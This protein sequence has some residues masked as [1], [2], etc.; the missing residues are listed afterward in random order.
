MKMLRSPGQRR[1]F[2]V[3][4]PGDRTCI[5]LFCD[6]S[7]A[8][9][10]PTL[11]ALIARIEEGSLRMPVTGGVCWVDVLEPG[12]ELEAGERRDPDP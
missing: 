7:A 6:A 2:I 9:L 5:D 3:F 8:D 11:K 12:P 4:D 1:A 10:V